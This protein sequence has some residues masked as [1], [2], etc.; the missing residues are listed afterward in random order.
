MLCI[1]DGCTCSIKKIHRKQWK[2][3]SISTLELEV[4]HRLKGRVIETSWKVANLNGKK[5][6]FMIS[7]SSGNQVPRRKR[8]FTIIHLVFNKGEGHQ[9][10]NIR[11]AF[12]RPQAQMQTG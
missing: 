9:Q 4:T 11:T 6:F 1:M 12:L 5:Y 8:I 7:G 3:I 10:E 2:E